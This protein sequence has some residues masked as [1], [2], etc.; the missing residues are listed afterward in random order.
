MAWTAATIANRGR[1]PDLTLRVKPRP[2][3]RRVFDIAT[4]RTVGRLMTG[5]V[6][7]GT[8][9]A[10]AIAGVRVAGKTGTAE[11]RSTV[12]DCKPP[13]PPVPGTNTPPPP[14][15][16]CIPGQNDPS[17]TDAWF[18]AFAPYAEPRV[19]V[20]VLLVGAGAGGETA[21]PAAKQVLEAALQRRAR[22]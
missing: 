7:F 2:R 15:E 11:L 13:E 10:A 1:R 14:P 8:G 19:A 4:A 5:V 9:T 16:T 20:G 12:G 3:L 18:A 21:A 22:S 6:K 17:N